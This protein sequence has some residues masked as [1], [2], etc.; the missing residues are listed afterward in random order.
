[1]MEEDGSTNY[2]DFAK[3]ISLLAISDQCTH[4]PLGNAV[5]DAI[6]ND[7][8]TDDRDYAD[9][10]YTLASSDNGTGRGVPD[11]GWMAVEP[12]FVQQFCF[13]Q[14]TPEGRDWLEL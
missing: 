1:M 6:S 11:N 9:S 10:W 3:A 13:A 8:W 12:C 7:W 2:R 14:R 4:I 5:L